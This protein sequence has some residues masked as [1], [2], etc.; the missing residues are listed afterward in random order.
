M[1]QTLISVEHRQ[2]GNPSPS[3]LQFLITLG[4]AGLV[5]LATS[6]SLDYRY[7]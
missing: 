6:E 3:Q 5:L 2:L 7:L 1:L 4:L